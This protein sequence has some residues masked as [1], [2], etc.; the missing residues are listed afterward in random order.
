MILR[1]VCS[2]PQDVG[3]ASAR[4]VIHQKHPHIHFVFYKSAPSPHI[5]TNKSIPAGYLGLTWTNGGV[6]GADK[7]PVS[8][9]NT[10]GKYSSGFAGYKD[11]SYNTA[12]IIR[13]AY[14]ARM[15]ASLN[16]D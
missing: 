6:I 12:Q 10:I 9:Y 4:R 5:L 13:S 7:W 3:V 2:N 14:R 16:L 11:S 15:R 1:Y 8:G